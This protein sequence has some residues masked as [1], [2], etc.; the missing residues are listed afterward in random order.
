MDDDVESVGRWRSHRSDLISVGFWGLAIAFFAAAAAIGPEGECGR[1]NFDAQVSASRVAGL[2]LFAS[3]L[4]MG[5]AAAFL[6]AG[7][8]RG[9]NRLANVI[10]AFTALVSLAV[11]CLTGFFAL[12]EVVAFQCL[13]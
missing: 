13:E 10:R 12:L 3:A 2:L 8:I 9:T 1:A 5:G 7:A 4:A 11:A 6:A